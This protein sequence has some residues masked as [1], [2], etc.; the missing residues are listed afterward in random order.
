M[1]QSSVAGQKHQ[2]LKVLGGVLALNLVAWG[3]FALAVAGHGFALRGGQ[4]FTAGLAASAFL[5]GVRHA[6]DADHIAAI[7]NTTRTLSGRGLPHASTGFWF[8][9]GHSSVVL[10]A[11]VLLAAGATALA[12]ALENPESLFLQITGVWGPAVAGSFLVLIGLINLVAL[13]QLVRSIRALRSGADTAQSLETALAKRGVLA[14]VIEPL[15][16]KVDSPA[17]LYPLGLLFGLGF[18]TAATIGLLVISGG[19]ALA[20]PWYVM[21]CLPLLFTAGMVTCDSLNGLAMGGVYRWA[22][23]EPV[24]RAGYA[25][26]VTTFS[27]FVAFAVAAVVLG[28]LV[29]TLRGEPVG[30]ISLVSGIDL[31][32]FGL[33]TAG[34]FLAVWLVSWGLWKLSAPRRTSVTS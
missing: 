8:A 6:F 33:I 26:V 30:V 10:G 1:T 25:L 17:K 12:G 29:E 5:L 19:A 2:V 22:H 16:R 9:L 32:Y 15:A 27:V 31:E 21:L 13:V 11:M 34:L 23:K 18:D 24:R 14:R 4:L 28:G 7:D 20:L 3:L